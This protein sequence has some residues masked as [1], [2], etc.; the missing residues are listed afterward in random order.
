ML[1]T[2]ARVTCE[3]TASYTRGRLPSVLP[4]HPLHSDSSAIE[5]VILSNDR[6]IDAFGTD[7]LTLRLDQTGTPQVLASDIQMD[8]LLRPSTTGVSHAQPL[9]ADRVD[10]R[11]QS[12]RNSPEPS[13]YV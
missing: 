10:S 6:V 7:H 5:Q 4:E 3:F 1:C 11:L 13:Q 8:H 2:Q 9:L 12:S